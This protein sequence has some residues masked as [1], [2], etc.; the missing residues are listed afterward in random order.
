M[1]IGWEV[2]P[3]DLVP[4]GQVVEGALPT[5]SGMGH[6]QVAIIDGGILDGHWIR[7]LLKVGELGPGAEE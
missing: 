6:G 7:A 5:P 3:I 2:L 1:L 4:A